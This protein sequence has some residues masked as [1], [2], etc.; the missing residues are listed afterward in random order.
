MGRLFKPFAQADSSTTR[1]FGGT[2]LGLAISRRLVEL[3]GGTMDV[4]SEVG[5]G[6]TFSFTATF[7][8]A[9]PER[10]AA[11]A[12]AAVFADAS[13]PRR[14]RVLVAEDNVVN[15]K[16]TVRMLERLGYAADV[17]ESGEEALRSARA[18]RYDVIL[19]DGQMPGMDGF[20]ATARIRGFEGPVRHTPIVAL[21]ASAMR[22]DRERCLAA[23][24]DD[25]IPKPFTPEQLETVLARWI[26]A[27]A[28]HR[29]AAPA[30]PMARPSSDPVD[31]DM[32]ADLVAMT[33]PAFVSDLMALFFK[34]AATALTDLRLAWRED[35]LSAWRRVAHKLRGSCAT[36][37]ARAMTETCMRMEEADEAAFLSGGESMLESLEA[38]FR[39]ARD[40]LS[41]REGKATEG[42]PAS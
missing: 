41:Q 36:L 19:M 35:D 5:V 28:A 16:V 10:P 26:P 15:Q 23:G 40:L 24:M 9:D 25:Y 17:A 2:G 42:E 27:A 38:E 7:E 29:N 14:G 33:P 11:A 30:P 21:T 22:G 8:K 31:W 32:V 3:M 34:D 1:R 12:P 18:A 39:T 4:T 37:G 13:A 6:S 20:E